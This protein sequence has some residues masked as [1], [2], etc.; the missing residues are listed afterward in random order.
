MYLVLSVLTINA[1][2]DKKTYAIALIISVLFGIIIEVLQ[3]L[4]QLG[5]TFSIMDIL[6]NF[7]GVC[8]GLT[9]YYFMKKYKLKSA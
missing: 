7:M 6:A 3:E 1:L 5:R 2:D 9:G 4:M 8:T